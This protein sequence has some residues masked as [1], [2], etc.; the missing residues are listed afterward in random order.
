MKAREQLNAEYDELI[1]PIMRDVLDNH[2]EHYSGFPE[3]L[4]R[5]DRVW[6]TKLEA[7]GYDV[8][9]VKDLMSQW[10]QTIKANS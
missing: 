6:V 4:Y 10:A 8:E 9:K 3:C 2:Y 7:L 5:M 1:Q